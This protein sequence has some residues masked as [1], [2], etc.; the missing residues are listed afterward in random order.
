[1][2]HVVANLAQRYTGRADVLFVY[3]NEAH[4]ADEWPI[5]YPVHATAHQSIEDRVGAACGFQQRSRWES[6]PVHIA[7]D[8]MENSAQTLFGAWPFRHFVLLNSKVLMRGEAENYTF[9]I[10]QV[11]DC[12]RSVLGFGDPAQ[13]AL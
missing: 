6:V 3:L 9:P 8:T 1:M 10:Y 12:L 13:E 7:A 4:A 5:S 11:E 2:T